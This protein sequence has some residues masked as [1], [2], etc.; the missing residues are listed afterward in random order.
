MKV[1]VLL[2]FLLCFAAVSGGG[3]LA[4][5]PHLISALN[6]E[7]RPADERA[8]DAGRKPHLVTAFLG[9]EPGHKVADL[10]TGTGYY[11]AF[12]AAAVGDEGR[13]ISHNSPFLV[14]RFAQRLG[15]GGFWPERA[16][17]PAW[18]RVTRVVAPLEEP[19][20]PKD[21]D[22]VIMV[23]FYHDTYWQEVDREKMNRAVFAALRPGG[24]Y[25]IVDHAAADG[26]GAR[27]VKS[28]HRV[29]EALVVKEITAAGFVLE[30]TANFLR[31]SADKRDYN[32]FRDA[33]TNRDQTDRFVLRFRKPSK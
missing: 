21:L 29:E 14:D 2:P 17:S 13:V 3:G 26:T 20:L 23:L 5:G 12:L 22:M 7:A 9:L 16:K 25:G 33:R 6:D 24:V 10:M 8:R 15:P 4:P 18:Q 31:N 30:D 28:L 1:A 27:D 19:R 11:T 32:V